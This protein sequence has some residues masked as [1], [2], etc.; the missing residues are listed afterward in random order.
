MPGELLEGPELVDTVEDGLR[1]VDQTTAHLLQVT[2]NG[3]VTVWL[4]P[5]GRNAHHGNLRV[6]GNY[7]LLDPQTWKREK[8]REDKSQ[9]C[10]MVGAVCV[11]S[12]TVLYEGITLMYLGNQ[13]EPDFNLNVSPLSL[14]M[15][16]EL[17]LVYQT[18]HTSAILNSWSPSESRYTTLQK[19]AR[20]LALPPYCDVHAD[21]LTQFALLSAFN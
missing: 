4:D 21:L 14:S 15:T 9:C 2:Q 13:W 12:G 18:T 7:F 11:L 10:S 16:D 3:D 6:W 8:E 17:A 19:V 5:W 20:L 1:P